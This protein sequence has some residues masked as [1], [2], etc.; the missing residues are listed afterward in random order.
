MGDGVAADPRDDGAEKAAL[1]GEQRLLRRT[2]WRLVLWSGLSTLVVLLLLGAALYVAVDNRL[3]TASETQLRATVDPLARSYS[4]TDP[5]NGAGTDHPTGTFGPQP[6]RGGV[7][8]FA[9]DAEGQQFGFGQPPSTR[10]LDGM[11]DQASLAAAQS[12]SSGIDMREEKLQV[13]T[14]EIPVRL[15][16][17]SFV[18][19]RNGQT[20]FIQAI[21]DRGVETETLRTLLVVLLVGGGLVVVV[22]VLFGWV[23]A[24]RALVPIR[25]SLEAQ[26]DAL[27]RQ[28]EFAADA[29]HELRTPLTVIRS[30]VEHLTRH[31]DK[32]VG[33]QRE[34]LDD[35]DA[36]VA[37][38]TMLVDDLLLLARSDSGAVA[39][40]RME[41]DLGDVAFEAAGALGRMA[42]DR[43]VHVEVDPEPAMVDGDPVRLR[44]LVSILVD[45][46]VR[47]SPREGHVR[48]RV[49]TAGGSASVEVTDEGPGVRD[50]DMPHVCDR[51]FRAPGAPSG[52]TGLGL[53]IAKWIV[54]RHG[55]RIGV[56]NRPEGG[57]AFRVEL[58]AAGTG[59]ATGSSPE[60]ALPPDPSALL[61]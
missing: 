26:R 42:E 29:S 24:R 48:V 31:P 17:E 9:F 52:G 46:A 45:N 3:V 33:E 6:G 38:L 39:L 43:G 37:H 58:P 18:Y 32:R 51:F 23:Y 11:P 57:A 1:A 15:L 5:D 7:W 35:I 27:R 54:D 59:L 22:S 53:A 28:R 14:T 44:Q 12:S 41:L 34:A 50:E 2:R 49:R 8:V 25:V 30:S 61:G 55:G 40:D 19:W 13:G 47:H 36:E 21:Q 16:T 20:L 60:A 10:A 56:A 4:R